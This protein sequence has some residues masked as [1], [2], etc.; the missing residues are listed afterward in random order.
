MSA[1]LSSFGRRHL[2]REWTLPGDGQGEQ[3]RE[4]Q[5]HLN[6]DLG[7]CPSLVLAFTAVSG[8]CLFIHAAGHCADARTRLK[9]ALSSRY[10]SL[11]FC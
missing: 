3:N 10:C 1:R 7:P 6:A 4:V 2:T 8:Q 5:H 9:L 11:A